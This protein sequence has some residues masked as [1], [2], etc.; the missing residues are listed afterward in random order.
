MMKEIWRGRRAPVVAPGKVKVV[1][2]GP[3]KLKNKPYRTGARVLAAI[4]RR[5]DCRTHPR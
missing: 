1:K 4:A 5:A 3:V 2:G